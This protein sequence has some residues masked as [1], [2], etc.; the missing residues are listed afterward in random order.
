M[1]STSLTLRS[2]Q[3]AEQRSAGQPYP[4]YID[5]LEAMG[6]RS[7]H[8]SVDT[9]DRRIFSGAHNQHIDIK[10][11]VTEAQPAEV[12]NLEQL[13]VALHRTQTGQPDYFAFM[14]EIAQAGV[15]FYVAD[16]INRKVSYFGKAPNPPYEENI[17]KS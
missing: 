14:R 12:F 11:E 5:N 7:Y 3:A 8:V 2:F 1:T 13:K 17:P 4:V 10:G 9:H 16:V 15:H 6:V